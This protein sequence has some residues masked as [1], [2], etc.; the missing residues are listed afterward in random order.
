MVWGAGAR[1]LRSSAEIEG[2]M[3]SAN[4]SP[5]ARAL[6]LD[7]QSVLWAMSRR[8]DRAPMREEG[9]ARAE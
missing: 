7:H 5:R 2:G 4:E 9:G 6:L 3:D 8:R 1:S